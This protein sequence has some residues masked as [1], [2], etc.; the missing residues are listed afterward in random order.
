MSK[1]SRVNVRSHFVSP[2]PQAT[3]LPSVTSCDEEW[4]MVVPSSASSDGGADGVTVAPGRAPFRENASPSRA[5]AVRL[6]PDDD[7][8]T[9]VGSCVAPLMTPVPAVD[10]RISKSE[11]RGATSTSAGAVPSFFTVNVPDLV[12]PIRTSR[13][14]DPGETV[15][16]GAASLTSFRTT[17]S[18]TTL[19]DTFLAL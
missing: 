4:V 3:E 17:A 13:D 2:A 11:D 14:S 8:L 9:S 6:A 10:P 18:A 5:A 19:T 1:S 16:S 15:R 12:P 7:V